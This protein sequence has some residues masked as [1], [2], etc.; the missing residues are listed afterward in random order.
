M[1]T[2]TENGGVLRVAD[3]AFI[4]PD[5]GNGAYQD[6]LA[7]V[8]AGGVAGS[9]APAPP[10]VKDFEAAVQSH[11]D[12]VAQSRGYTNGFAVIT[13]ENS[14][15]QAWATEAAV[16]R[17]WRDAVWLYAYTQF[18]AVQSGARGVPAIA[19]FIA[20]LPIIEWPA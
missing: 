7:W 5:A 15:V 13:Y 2:K 3:G 8:E 1:Y 4:P 6:Y 11:V 17:A 18:G 14:A 20:E 9:V 12:A 10:S 19:E 16:F